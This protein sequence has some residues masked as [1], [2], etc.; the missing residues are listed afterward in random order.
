MYRQLL[1]A[2]SLSKIYFETGQTSKS[3][4]SNA[5]VCARWTRAVLASRGEKPRC[6]AWLTRRTIVG[7]WRQF[8]EKRR[9][10]PTANDSVTESA[11][12]FDSLF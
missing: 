4:Q 2:L 7:R 10:D 11:R 9:L 3:R 1:R 8:T 5:A 6:F 12:H